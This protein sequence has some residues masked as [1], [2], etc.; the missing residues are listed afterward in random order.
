VRDRLRQAFGRWGRPGQ[1]RVDNGAPWG[2]KGDLPPDLALWLLGL[3]VDVVWNRP[4]R[5]TD[6]AVVER[7]HGVGANWAEPH[8]Q[9]SAAALQERMAEMD[10]I[11]REEYPGRDGR[12]RLQAYPGLAH[13][14]RP[15]SP[16]WERRHWSLQR[17]LDCLAGLAVR[18]RIDSKGMASLYNRNY[19]VGRHHAGREVQVSLDP[20]RRSWVFSDEQGRQLREVPAEQLTRRRILSL[21]VSRRRPRQPPVQDRG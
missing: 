19:Y 6:N 16:A 10:R 17:V 21:T 11:Q 1:V 15:Y 4:G 20:Q 9:G 8:A 14:G 5:A 7:G 2:S 18:R 13:S 3:G 12:S